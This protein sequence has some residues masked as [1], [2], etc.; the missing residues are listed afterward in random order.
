MPRNEAWGNFLH[1]RYTGQLFSLVIT[2]LYSVANL[3]AMNWLKDE[4]ITSSD[5]TKIAL[6]LIL[7]ITLAGFLTW[8]KDCLNE[9]LNM[10]SL[11]NKE[12]REHDNT[13]KLLSN[14][15][16]EHKRVLGVLNSMHSNVTNTIISGKTDMEVVNEMRG[17][18]TS[19]NQKV[20]M[21]Y[22]VIDPQDKESQLYRSLF[23][24][25]SL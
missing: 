24:K 18:L 21:N 17:M 20:S 2:L 4:L 16:A 10:Q 19:F 22:D 1:L 6:G 14:K 5:S 7:A 15:E 25:D 3:F 23:S 13:K 9:S 8:L 11:A 12:K